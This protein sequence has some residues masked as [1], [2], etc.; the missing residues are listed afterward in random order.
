MVIVTLMLNVKMDWLVELTTVVQLG[1]VVTTVAILHCVT[2][3][4]VQLGIAVVSIPNVDKD[5]EIAIQM[6]NARTDWSAKLIVVDQIGQRDTI[7]V[8][9][10]DHMTGIQT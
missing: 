9:F 6:K 4:K 1:L 10:H 3:M 5:L 8:F 7:V 2:T